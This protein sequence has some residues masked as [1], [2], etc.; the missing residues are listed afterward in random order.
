MPKDTLQQ[1]KQFYPISNSL[2]EYLRYYKRE[3]SLPV[4]YENLLQSVDSYPLMNDKNQDTLWQTMVYDQHYGK[5]IFDGLKEIYVLLRSGGD[6]KI[7]PNL[8]VDRVD[9]CTFG[10][11]KPFRIRI[12][13]QSND[14]HDYF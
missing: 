14:N 13:N 2:R 10:N 8:Y 4:E 7:L 5:D 9:Y 6:Q 12:V 1:K 11:T 3:L